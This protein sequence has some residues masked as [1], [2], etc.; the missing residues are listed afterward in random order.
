MASIHGEQIKFHKTDDPIALA[1]STG[2]R[3]N[4][5]RLAE[6]IETPNL[7][8]VQL[9]SYS[10]FLQKEISANKRKNEGLQ[11]VFSEVFPIESYDEKIKL[12]F[13]AY[14][15]GEPK[16]SPLE[17]QRESQTFA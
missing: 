15:I 5:G 11:A 14:E 8:E 4:F 6:A 17:R 9:N 16:L 1:R 12:E 7:I 2:Q 3:V 13:A 10:D